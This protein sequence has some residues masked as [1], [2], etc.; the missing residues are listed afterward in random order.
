[1]DETYSLRLNRHLELG[2]I[3]RDV[4]GFGLRS[5]HPTL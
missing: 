3:S 4:G 2:K 1:M 5:D